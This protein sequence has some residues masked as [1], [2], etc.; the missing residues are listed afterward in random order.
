MTTAEVARRIGITQSAV[1]RA[2]V[3]GER[4]AKENRFEMI[5]SNEEG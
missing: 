5:P 4:L 3:R 2:V 1:S